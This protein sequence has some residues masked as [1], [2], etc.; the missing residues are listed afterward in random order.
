MTGVSLNRLK[1][2]LCLFLERSKPEKLLLIDK[3]WRNGF[4]VYA[5][6]YYSTSVYM[7]FSGPER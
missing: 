2:A 7:V 4:H 3:K 6:G 1:E 5:W